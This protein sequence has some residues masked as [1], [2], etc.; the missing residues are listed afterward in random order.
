[1]DAVTRRCVELLAERPELL[2][3]AHLPERVVTMKSSTASAGTTVQSR[4][5][6][7]FMILRPLE[8]QPEVAPAIDV[9]G[10]ASR[11]SGRRG[12]AERRSIRG[13]SHDGIWRRPSLLS[14]GLRRA[15]NA[16]RRQPPGAGRGCFGA[17]L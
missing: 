2:P 3:E 4:C 16:S 8:L 15:C 9:E 5:S 7:P 14:F 1:M 13:R 17:R 10:Q 6:Q 12:R 11:P